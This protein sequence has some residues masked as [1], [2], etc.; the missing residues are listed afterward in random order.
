MRRIAILL[1]AMSWALVCHGQDKGTPAN[2]RNPLLDPVVY[3][4]FSGM[5]ENAEENLAGRRVNREAMAVLKEVYGRK[6]MPANLVADS[7]GGLATFLI[8]VDGCDHLP[9]IVR[10]CN[11]IAVRFYPDGYD[12]MHI[13][14]MADEALLLPTDLTPE[15][16]KAEI[17]AF[18]RRN[19]NPPP[20]RTVQVKYRSKVVVARKPAT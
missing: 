13:G 6:M 20:E 17:E 10:G 14:F 1:V 19:L 3:V 18:L 9:R 8:H 4:W 16:M 2:A 5:E 15:V 11:V 7:Q 12:P